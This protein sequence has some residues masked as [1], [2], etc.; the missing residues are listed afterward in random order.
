MKYVF[1]HK[2]NEKDE[3][4]CKCDRPAKKQVVKK[5]GK[6]QVTPLQIFVQQLLVKDFLFC[7]KEDTKTKIN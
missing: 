5:E 1:K 4:K 2:E 7:K 6:N 3:V